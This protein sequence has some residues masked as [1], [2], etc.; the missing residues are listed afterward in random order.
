MENIME[1]TKVVLDDCAD[2]T[3]NQAAQKAD[4]YM[5]ITENESDFIT[6]MTVFI[7]GA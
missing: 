4:R 2:K 6:G 3:F 1:Q 5:P 7:E